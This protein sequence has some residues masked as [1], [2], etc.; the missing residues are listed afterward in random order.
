MGSPNP[1]LTIGASI[2]NDTLS[3]VGS[4]SPMAGRRHGTVVGISDQQ[5]VVAPGGQTVPVRRQSSMSSFDEHLAASASSGG[6][7][8]LLP[9]VVCPL[10]GLTNLPVNTP[11][12]QITSDDI[13]QLQSM[14]ALVSTGER[15]RC[16]NFVP[17]V[18]CAFTEDTVR[19]FQMHHGI[20]ITGEVDDKTWEALADQVAYKKK[21][22]EERAHKRE[23][24]QK[25]AKLEQEKRLQQQKEESARAMDN[26]LEKTLSLIGGTSGPSGMASSAGSS[27]AVGKKNSGNFLQPQSPTGTSTAPASVIGSG[28]HT[29]NAS[30]QVIPIMPSGSIAGKPL[31][32]KAPV[33]GVATVQGQQHSHIPS[34]NSESGTA[35]VA[36]L[37]SG[38]GPDATM[39][40]PQPPHHPPVI[41]P[42]SP[43]SPSRK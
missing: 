29:I 40:V 8:G 28:T 30:P 26:M 2:P 35:P 1:G 33:V 5:G 23:E 13:K 27:M 11:G 25:K 19:D 21:K 39:V 41:R 14:L 20:E 17:G 10:G 43:N 7:V 12:R 24:A 15:G 4:V 37:L 3:S 31:S 16:S 32:P 34:G 9:G 36:A 6:V 22:E 42:T 18:Y 38:T